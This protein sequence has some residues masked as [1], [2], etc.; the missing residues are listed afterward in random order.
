MDS[1]SVFSE[2]GSGCGFLTECT[3]ANSVRGICPEGWHLPSGIE[4][5]QLI[6]TKAT[7]PSG[8]VMSTASGTLLKSRDWTSGA[9]R[10]YF[11]FSAL[12]VGHTSRGSD[13]STCFWSAASD[14]VHLAYAMCLG[15]GDGADLRVVGKGVAYSVRCLKDK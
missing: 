3:P 5:E 9:G 15:A 2:T 13:E 6:S 14:V 11:G 7:S 4:F 1:A 12:P 10:D 8:S